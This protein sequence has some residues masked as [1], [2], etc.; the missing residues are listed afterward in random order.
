MPLTC[1]CRNSAAVFALICLSESGGA[2]LRSSMGGLAGVAIFDHEATGQFGCGLLD[3]YKP[4]SKF[5]QTDAIEANL[6][7]L[8][9]CV[10]DS[11]LRMGNLACSAL[12]RKRTNSRFGIS[13]VCL[14]DRRTGKGWGSDSNTYSA[15]FSVRIIPPCWQGVKRNLDVL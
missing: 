2:F 4:S 13:H 7:T 12:N 11:T 8:F 10:E 3:F 1:I 14:L 15:R 9:L 5:R 6:A